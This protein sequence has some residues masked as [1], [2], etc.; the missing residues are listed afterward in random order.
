MDVL[1]FIR[2]I[3]QDMNCS[4]RANYSATRDMTPRERYKNLAKTFDGILEIVHTYYNDEAVVYYKERSK[5]DA[6]LKKIQD[7][8][9]REIERCIK[10]MECFEQH[11]IEVD[12]VPASSFSAR[13][14]LIGDSDIDFA[15]M[16]KKIDRNKVICISNALGQCGFVYNDLR[17]EHSERHIHW[18][19]QKYIDDVEIEGK[20]RDMA[21]FKEL[22]KMHA[23]LD[24]EA[25]KKQKELITFTKFLLKKHDKKGYD[26][27]KMFYYCWGGYHGKCRELMYPLLK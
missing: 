7:E 21:G 3:K 2:M 25:T 13:T 6:G 20:V 27:F 24:N 18:V 4:L 22:L 12:V 8:S 23:F 5:H 15:V 11:K 26:L 10:D 17:N 19:F 16:V 14:H 1:K 9:K